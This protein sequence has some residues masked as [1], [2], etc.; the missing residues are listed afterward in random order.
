MMMPIV[1]PETCYSLE[2]DCLNKS[3]YATAKKLYKRIRKENPVI[4][5]WIREWAKKTD[6]KTGAM[7][8]AL[9][10]YRLLESQIEADELNKNL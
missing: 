10:T 2:G 3:D 5:L 4:A 6:D 7:I 1:K 9:V 8:C